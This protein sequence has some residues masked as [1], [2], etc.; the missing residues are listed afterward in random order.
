MLDEADRMLDMG[1]ADD[2]AKVAKQCPAQ[3]QTLQ[4]C[5][6]RSSRI[7]SLRCSAAGA[8]RRPPLKALVVAL[9]VVCVLMISGVSDKASLV[10]EGGDRA[11]GDWSGRLVLWPLARQIWAQHP[12][13]GIGM[14]GFHVESGT[15]IGA[16]NVLLEMG[17]SLGAVGLLLFVALFWTTLANGIGAVDPR[18]RAVLLGAFLLAS[19]PAY[20]S[21][22]WESA[23]ASWV[24]LA[25]FSRLA[26]LAPAPDPLSV[27]SVGVP[28]G[29]MVTRPR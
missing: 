25:V 5:G 3:R 9:L 1:F 13:N 11:T 12:L 6:A 2:I 28:R 21:G 19:A 16:H 26:V 14:G 29:R 17:V 24:V 23:P 8:A 22:T 18:L 20:L 10:F 4:G 15:G 27:G 7:S